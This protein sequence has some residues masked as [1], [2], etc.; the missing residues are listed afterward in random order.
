MLSNAGIRN[1][2]EG[3]LGRLLIDRLGSGDALG[4]R[5]GHVIYLYE[6][7]TNVSE[8]WK[9]KLELG[10]EGHGLLPESGIRTQLT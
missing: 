2:E 7:C 1:H 10:F 4:G 3:G 5:I 6:C 8:K 9:I